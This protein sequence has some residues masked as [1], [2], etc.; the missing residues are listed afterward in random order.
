MPYAKPAITVRYHLPAPLTADVDQNRAFPGPDK[1]T[2]PLTQSLPLRPP[3]SKKPSIAP[4]PIGSQPVWTATPRTVRSASSSPRVQ[5]R[6]K[7]V[8]QGG[9]VCLQAWPGAQQTT[10][11]A[12]EGTSCQQDPRKARCKGEEAPVPADSTGFKVLLEAGPR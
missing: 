11:S 2:C 6:G 4:P 1:T 8:L 12:C 3:S 10:G 5:M 7:V 9:G